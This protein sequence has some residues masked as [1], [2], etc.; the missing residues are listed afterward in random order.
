MPTP[1]PSYNGGAA[2]SFLLTD[3]VG[4]FQ[5]GDILHYMYDFSKWKSRKVPKTFNS[6]PHLDRK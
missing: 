4:N 3:P 6:D 5:D 2:V 1:S